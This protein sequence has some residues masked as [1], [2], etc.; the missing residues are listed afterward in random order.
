MNEE[1]IQGTTEANLITAL[2][3]SQAD[4]ITDFEAGVDSIVELHDNLG[5]DLTPG[6]VSED[7]FAIELRQQMEA[8]AL[9]T[10]KLQGVCSLT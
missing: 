1:L 5:E 6:V 3:G 2:A 9:S 8:I 7:Q 10:M 4:Q